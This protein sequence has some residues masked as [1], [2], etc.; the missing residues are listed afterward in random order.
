MVSGLSLV[1]AVQELSIQTVITPLNELAY[2]KIEGASPWSDTDSDRTR[3]GAGEP[4]ELG[5]SGRESGGA[6]LRD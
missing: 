5:G 1:T 3:T 2:Q 6:G 4:C